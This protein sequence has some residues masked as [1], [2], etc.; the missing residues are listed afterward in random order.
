VY[1]CSIDTWRPP[2]FSFLSLFFF[3][4][5]FSFIL[6]QTLFFNKHPYPPFSFFSSF[7]FSVLLLTVLPRLFSLTYT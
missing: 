4:L 5:S 7:S 6:F 3:S 1:T 2:L